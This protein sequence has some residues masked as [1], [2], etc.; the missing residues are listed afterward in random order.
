[1]LQKMFVVVGISLFSLIAVPA[2]AQETATLALRNG[3]RP[4]G[5]LIDLN[6]SGF[7]LRVNGQD[8]QFP[9]GD[10]AAVEFVGGPLPGDAQN[11]VTRGKPLSCCGTDKS[12]KDASATSEV[13]VRCGSQWT[14]RVD[15]ANSRR[16]MSRN[17]ISPR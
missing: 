5:E 9:A 11:R 6:A 10:V 4:S 15:N 17:C 2:H 16:A 7:T 3:E 14:P 12:S 13:H 8:R 1:M